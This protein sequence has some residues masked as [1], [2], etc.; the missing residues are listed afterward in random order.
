MESIVRLSSLKI[1]NIKNV[2]TGQIVMPNTYQKHLAY[3]SAEVLG[4]YGQNGSGKT[5]IID[6]LYYLQKIMIGNTLD[7]EIADY[8]DRAILIRKGEIIDDLL[9]AEIK[10]S[11]KTLIEIVKEKYDYRADRIKKAVDQIK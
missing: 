2:R 1:S 7:E 9:V 6:T 3:K 8:I 5:A 11:G 10:S 4:L